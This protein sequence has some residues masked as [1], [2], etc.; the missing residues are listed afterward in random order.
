MPTTTMGR[1]DINRSLHRWVSC[2]EYVWG[3]RV[4]YSGCP[5]RFFAA[6]SDVVVVAAIRSVLVSC[7]TLLLA[8]AMVQR[9]G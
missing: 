4:T 6:A 3:T 5:C 1:G 9:P 8:L 7:V 2:G